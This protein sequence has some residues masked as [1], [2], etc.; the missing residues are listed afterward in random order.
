MPPVNANATA[1]LTAPNSFQPALPPPANKLSGAQVRNSQTSRN[2]QILPERTSAGGSPAPR[3]SKL[4]ISCPKY[5][6][7]LGAKDI[8]ES[9]KEGLIYDQESLE[10]SWSKVVTLL[11]ERH[12][13]EKDVYQTLKSGFLQTSTGR[14]LA[15][16]FV[17]SIMR[18]IRPLGNLKPEKLREFVEV[19]CLLPPARW[20]DSFGE[21]VNF[22]RG[23]YGEGVHGIIQDQLTSARAERDQKIAAGELLDDDTWK[24]LRAFTQE[25]R[26]LILNSSE[27]GLDVTLEKLE[28]LIHVRPSPKEA[29]MLMDE[30]VQ[31][32]SEINSNEWEGLLS[33]FPAMVQTLNHRLEAIEIV[34]NRPDRSWLEEIAALGVFSPISPKDIGGAVNSMVL[35]AH[36]FAFGVTPEPASAEKTQSASPSR[37]LSTMQEIQLL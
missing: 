19:I 2:I 30:L 29:K 18:S 7:L 33:L 25:M 4:P 10:K 37:L 11:Q 32:M 6:G 14:V 15:P 20:A 31:G 36:N 13:S 5:K 21:N 3:D 1:F 27:G 35:T 28:D 8:P 22:P 9:L 26:E 34:D 12:V 16:L 23:K 24:V 17:E